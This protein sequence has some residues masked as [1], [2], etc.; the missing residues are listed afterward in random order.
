MTTAQLNALLSS[1]YNR[2][3]GK[4]GEAMTPTRAAKLARGDKAALCR[5]AEEKGID[6]YTPAQCREAFALVVG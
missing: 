5:I 6:L 4:S 2:H 1:A 3:V